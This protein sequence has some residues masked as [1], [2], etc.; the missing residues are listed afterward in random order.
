MLNL[1]TF[2]KLTSFLFHTLTTFESALNTAPPF[3]PDAAEPN[4]QSTVFNASP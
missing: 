1:Q 3:P 2:A 4:I